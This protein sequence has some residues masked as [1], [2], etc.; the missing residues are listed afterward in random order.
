VRDPRDLRRS[1]SIDAAYVRD[2]ATLSGRGTNIGELGPQWSRAFLAL[3]VWLS[4]AAHGT[5]AYGRRIAHDVELARYLDGRVREHPD[6][7]PM[8]PVTLSIACFRYAPATAALDPARL[9][10][11]NE[12]L[13]VAIRRDGRAFPS[14]AELGGRYCLRAC[15]VNHRTEASDIDALVDATVE[16]GA[17]LCA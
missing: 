4:L 11:L 16:L 3:K 5:E 10:A 13:M 15:L 2:D 6:L 9:D 1:Y 8:C 17:K 12:R 14:N 7:E